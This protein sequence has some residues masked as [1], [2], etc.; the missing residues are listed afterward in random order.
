MTVKHFT[1]KQLEIL[2]ANP[3]VVTASSKAITYS[4]DFKMK[5]IEEYEQGK[6]PASIFEEAGFDLQILGADRIKNA[7]SRW[8]KAVKQDGTLGLRDARKAKSGRPLKRTLTP[9]EQIAKLEAENLYLKGELDFIKKLEL[10]EK[11]N[12]TDK[13]VPALAFSLIEKLS[14]KSSRSIS[15]FCRLAGVSRSGY[16][17]YKKSDF[18]V[19]KEQREL[20]LKETI[21]QAIA[22][23]SKDKGTRSIVMT[24]KNTFGII[25]NRKCVQ[26]ICRKFGLLSSVRKA[27]PYR[28]L[29]KATKEHRV[30]GNHLQRAFKPGVAG[31]VLLT[32]V[33]YLPYGNH[34]MAYLSTVK[35]A[36]TNEILAYQL[37]NNLKIEFVLNTIK[38]LVEKHGNCWDN[39]PQESFFG[40]MKDQCD[41]EN[42]QSYVEVQAVVDDYMDYYNNDRGQWNLKKLAPINYRYQ[43]TTA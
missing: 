12:Q 8:K 20:T 7:T 3:N 24:L 38:Q 19:Q 21:E 25:M 2:L 27:N 18:R 10:S 39:A 41:F 23:R 30:V 26:R 33:T 34:A 5:F 13:L 9:E 11:G 37:S 17:A 36:Q 15:L 29:A 40:H 22:F 32:D 43:L 6:S 35:D 14:K 28:R 4:I 1:P 42:F 16:Y 31:K